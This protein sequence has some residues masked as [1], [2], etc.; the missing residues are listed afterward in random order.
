MR[1]TTTMKVENKLGEPPKR[2]SITFSKSFKVKNIDRDTPIE[3][4]D[5]TVEFCLGEKQQPPIGCVMERQPIDYTYADSDIRI[6]A[7]SV[8]VDVTYYC[9]PTVEG[10]GWEYDSDKDVMW[11]SE[12]FTVN[13]SIGKTYIPLNHITDASNMG[14]Y[15]TNDGDAGFMMGNDGIPDELPTSVTSLEDMLRESH[16]FNLPAISNYDISRVTDIDYALASC[17]S[18]NQ[19]LNWDYSAVT[20]ANGFLSGNK[21][22]NQPMP[23]AKFSS[24]ASVNELLYGCTAFSQDLTTWCVPLLTVTPRNF[25]VSTKVTADKYP[26]WGTC[27]SATP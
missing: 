19:P 10:S 16:N 27:P 13:R 25:A 21:V 9:T 1:P 7:P 24:L 26:K 3:L 12:K 4:N 14:R 6:K 23:Y 5:Q 22:Y 20:S 8:A 18:F 11:L 15:W 2:A 17:I